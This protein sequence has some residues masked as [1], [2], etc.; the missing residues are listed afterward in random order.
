MDAVHRT[1]PYLLFELKRLGVTESMRW[2]PEDGNTHVVGLDLLLG[3]V[4]AVVS[5]IEV[6][7]G[8]ETFLCD[9]AARVFVPFRPLA[10][11]ET[12]HEPHHVFIA[13]EQT[14]N[15][16]IERAVAAWER[17]GK[18]PE[19]P[20][21]FRTD[22]VSGWAGFH[23][24]DP[25]TGIWMGVAVPDPEIFG[26]ALEWS[27]QVVVV[28]LL[29]LF[30]ALLLAVRLVRKY[31][32]QLKDVPK[33][34][35]RPKAFER[36]VRRL[37]ALGEGPTLEFKSTVRMNLKSGKIGKEIE[38]A[39]LKGA[40][41]FMNT[42]GGTLLIG[43]GDDGEILGVEPDQF[44]NE[45]KCRLHLKNLVNRHIGAEHS[46]SI[47]FE[48]GEVEGKTLAVV[49]CERSRDP[50]FL[51]AKNKELFYIRSGPSSV[52]LTSREVL[53]YVARRR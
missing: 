35:V 30:G 6:S 43:V 49:Q 1:E 28:L 46:T 39:W 47:R 52:E 36:D 53:E 16:L 21:A 20:V 44:E 13:A 41:A 18:P 50:V 34:L 14:G 40:T 8:S 48:V 32:H 9:S 33:Q 45:D 10:P 29:I 24:V 38:L 25:L 3:D 22:T 26:A 12:P 51:R 11:G 4:F 2:T 27:P 5:E 37:I 31:A 42:D 23:L 19:T 17:E 7:E 15:A